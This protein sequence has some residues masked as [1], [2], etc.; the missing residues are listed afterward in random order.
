MVGP[1]ESWENISN[2]DIYKKLFVRRI[3][4]QMQNIFFKTCLLLLSSYNWEIIQGL[5]CCCDPDW[6]RVRPMLISADTDLPSLTWSPLE[7]CWSWYNHW[8]LVPGVS[9]SDY[10]NV[11][12]RGG[13]WWFNTACPPPPY[14]SHLQV[15]AGCWSSTRWWWWCYIILKAMCNF[16]SACKVITVVTHTF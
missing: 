12:L 3:K 5:N 8:S 15:V 6:W 9:V 13:L 1:R 7:H 14:L 2:L 4:H 16:S 10:D 11:P